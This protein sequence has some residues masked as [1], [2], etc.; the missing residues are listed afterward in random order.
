VFCLKICIYI[1]T[2]WRNHIARKVYSIS[3]FLDFS[4]VQYS[5]Y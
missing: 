3:G 1:L 5:R 4:I 2:M